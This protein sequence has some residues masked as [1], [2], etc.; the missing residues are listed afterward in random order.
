MSI[1]DVLQRLSQLN[2]TILAVVDENFTLMGVVTDD[3]LQR[4]LAEGALLQDSIASVF[5]EDPIKGSIQQNDTELQQLL[6]EAKID[7]LPIVDPN[8]SFI[9]FEQLEKKVIENAVPNLSEEEIKCVGQA[10]NS[11]FVALGP[12]NTEFENAIC[13]FSRSKYAVATN[14]GTSALHLSLI[15]ANVEPH[16]IVLTSTLSFAATANA[17]RYVQSES[18]ILMWMS[19]AYA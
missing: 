2:R 12:H 18:G 16:D 17:I 4:A 15:A 8:G 14:S 9:R 5:N 11:N 10:I 7:Q 1:G 3:E 19:R 6:S 13:E